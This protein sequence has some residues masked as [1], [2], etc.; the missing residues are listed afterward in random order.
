MNPMTKKLFLGIVIWCCL[1]G[2]GAG[3]WA[4]V[5]EGY[6]SFKLLQGTISA[7]SNHGVAVEHSR[8]ETGASELYLPFDSK[9]KLQG[10]SSIGEIHSGDTVLVE[11]REILM[12][13]GQGKYSRSSRTAVRLALVS[14][15]PAPRLEPELSE[16]ISQDAD[17]AQQ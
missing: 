13:D 14:R 10:I 15:A 11:Y 4:G 9:L 3:V 5:E 8:T 17:D 6:T 1:C 16:G 12:K 7:I 2:F